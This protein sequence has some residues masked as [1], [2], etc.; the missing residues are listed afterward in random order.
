M[1]RIEPPLPTG[2]FVGKGFLYLHIEA[3]ACRLAILLTQ[4]PRLQ[5]VTGLPD[6]PK[7]EAKGVIL[8]RTVVRDPGYS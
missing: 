4:S 1:K 3:G 2:Y 8:V 6:S 7:T 5:V